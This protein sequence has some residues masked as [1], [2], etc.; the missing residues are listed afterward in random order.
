MILSLKYIEKERKIKK[1]GSRENHEKNIGGI[2]NLS[3][4]TVCDFRI[5]Y[6]LSPLSRL[7]RHL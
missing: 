7:L 4:I 2:E 5:K 3:T 1:K 6:H